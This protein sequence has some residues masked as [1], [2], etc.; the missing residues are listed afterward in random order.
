MAVDLR[1]FRPG[2]LDAL[3]A[4]SLATGHQGGDASALYRDPTLMGAIYSAPYAVLAPRLVIVAE[5]D[6][7]VVG[8]AVGTADTAAFEARLEHDWWPALRAHH[9]APD[10]A[11][12]DTWTADERRIHAFYH[13]AA[14]P[15]SILPDFPAHM[16]MNLLPQAQGKGVGTALLTRWLEGLQRETDAVRGVHV[17]AN[18]QN[19]RACHFWQARGFQPLS[20]SAEEV[21]RRTRWFGLS[22]A[23]QA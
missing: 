3:Y 5:M 17:G 20:L 11:R 12:H 8:Y 2:D 4:I 23:R 6:G 13:P 10:P 22:L 18:K 19:A 7:D 15:R 9:T 14:A 1:P 16:H 21:T